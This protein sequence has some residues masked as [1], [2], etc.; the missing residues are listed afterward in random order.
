MF[1]VS[2]ASK[3]AGE[4]T[5]TVPVRLNSRMEPFRALP[6]IDTAELRDGS[7]VM[8]FADHTGHVVMDTTA[9]YRA[10]NNPEEHH[11]AKASPH[12]RAENR[13]CACNVEQLDQERLPGW[14]GHEVHA[15]LLR[16][17]RRLTVIRCEHALD[18][19]SV[20]E[21]SHNQHRKG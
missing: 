5:N 8:P 9:Q 19:P 20:H 10:E 1:G 11:G 18:D 6:Q 2:R 7:A 14:H 15:V 21:V 17:G 3:A 4:F 12:Q 13:P 16:I